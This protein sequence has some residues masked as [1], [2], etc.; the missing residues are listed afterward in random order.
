MVT[1]GYRKG[2]YEW[3]TLGIRVRLEVVTAAGAVLRAWAAERASLDSRRDGGATNTNAVW[4]GMDK[5]VGFRLR[6]ERA[7]LPSCLSEELSL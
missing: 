1:K 5:C 3:V 7:R 2:V 6:F 4:G